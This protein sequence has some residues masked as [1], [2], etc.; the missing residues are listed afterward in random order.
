MHNQIRY[1]NQGETNKYNVL[2]AHHIVM[3]IIYPSNTEDQ[4]IFYLIS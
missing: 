3:A 1:T 4:P 2:K